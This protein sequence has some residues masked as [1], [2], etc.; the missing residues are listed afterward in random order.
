MG[1]FATLIGALVLVVAACS[2]STTTA[3]TPAPVT[4]TPTATPAPA[5]PTPAATRVTISTTV[6]WDGDQCTYAGPAAVPY[7]A[8]VEFAMTN[9]HE[10][11]FTDLYVGPV[12]EGTTW[13]Q[14][15]EWAKSPD[16]VEP[17]F[18][19]SFDEF[20]W[21]TPG[22]AESTPLT[23]VITRR[24]PYLVLC[25]RGPETPAGGLLAPAALLSVLEG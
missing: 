5:V 4:P 20:H 8:T 18:F 19:P 2:G 25:S 17:S 23:A 3:P 21:L 14:V 10:T 15:V 11:D 9:T 7:M 16:E 24:L 1:R 6:T 12:I 22:E 13:E